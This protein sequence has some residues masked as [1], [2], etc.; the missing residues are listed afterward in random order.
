V[1]WLPCIVPAMVLD[2]NHQQLGI[3]YLLHRVPAEA[4]G[5]LCS[6]MRLPVVAI[7]ATI[8]DNMLV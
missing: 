5:G 1:V 2:A 3:C 6:S 7:V 8:D 4:M